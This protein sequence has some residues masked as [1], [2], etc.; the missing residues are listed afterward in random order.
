MANNT[1]AV[2]QFD[3]VDFVRKERKRITDE[4]RGLSAKE[5]V[6]Y[7]NSKKEQAKQK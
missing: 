3:V 7:F 6:A 1:K 4:T 5:I 2:K